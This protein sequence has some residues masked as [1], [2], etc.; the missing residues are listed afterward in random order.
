MSYILIAII[1][2]L[3]TGVANVID[4]VV[5]EKYLKAA[6]IYA[7]WISALAILFILLIPFGVTWLGLGLILPALLFGMCFIAGFFMMNA[8]LLQ[9]ETSRVITT[10]GGSLPIFTLTLSYLFL[11]E[12]LT[13]NQYLAFIILV[14]GIILMGL[15]RKTLLSKD[16][17][18]IWYAIGAGFF[19]AISFAGSKYIFNN[20][21]FISGFFW[22]RMGGLLCAPLILLIPKWRRE[23]VADIH[24]PGADQ[25]TAKGLA[26][27]NQAIGGTGFIFLSYA[28]S[29]GSPTIVNAL[30]GVQY[31]FI[32]LVTALLGNKIPQL[33]ENFNRP[34]VIQKIIAILL[35]VTGLFIL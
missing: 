12:I 21:S 14:L 35:I 34:I 6:S 29:I 17:H 30:Q 32:F 16:K 15:E 5:V 28:I 27:V 23:I 9:G 8:G 1:S 24:Q 13:N 25:K 31:G 18:S 19:F 3:I 20:M 4:K 11:G 26:L 2:H 33:K 22:M 10:I 7:F